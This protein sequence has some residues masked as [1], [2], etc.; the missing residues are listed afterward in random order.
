MP[1]L[2][3][4]RRERNAHR[5][6]HQRAEE[7]LCPLSNY[8]VGAAVL[9]KSGKIYSGCN[10]ENA[11]YGL[12]NCAERT[13][14]FSAVADG[15]K[16][17]E[18]IAISIK[19]CGMP[20]GACRQVLNEFNPNMH[21]LITDGQG[22]V[23]YANLDQLLPASFGPSNLKKKD[24]MTYKIRRSGDRGFFDHGWLKTYHT[25]SFASYHDPKFMG[26]RD[27]RVINEDSIAPGKGFPSH[28][29]QDMEILTVLIEGELAHKD[30]MGNASVI[31]TGEVQGM[32]A[33]KGVIHS[34][35]NPSETTPTHLLQ[36]WIQPDTKGVTP[37]YQDAKLPSTPNQWQLIASKSG[38]ENSLKIHQDV[39]LSAITLESGKQAEKTLGPNRYGWLQVIDGDLSFNEDTLQAGDGVAIEPNTAVKIKALASFPL[40]LLRSEMSSMKIK[41]PKNIDT[42]GRWIRFALGVLLLIY[43]Y[44]QWSR[45]ASIFALFVLF[46]SLM[47][48]C[49]V[50][51]LLGKNSRPIKKK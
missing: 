22:R 31:H 35:Y 6:G 17:I 32:S 39:E 19:D 2:L 41:I 49:I 1:Q 13:A 43:A 46:E 20:C 27:L 26:F 12:T 16:E 14:I 37:R 42:T 28:D 21:V 29:H 15:E 24:L 50:Y 11:S 8:F 5:A 18:A 23:E 25:F 7:S 30:N 36:I 33:G 45:I 3:F 38:R 48:W 40:P 51:Q 44:W 4:L 34:E 9:T 10:V 47:S